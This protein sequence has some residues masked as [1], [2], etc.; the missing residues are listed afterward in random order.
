MDR[1]DDSRRFLVR[2]RGPGRLDVADSPKREF[3]D[4][5][6]RVNTGV[7][8]APNGDSI[9][10]F[11]RIPCPTIEVEAG[12]EFKFFHNLY[13]APTSSRLI[14]GHW[15]I[16]AENR[17]ENLESKPAEFDLVFSE[18]SV[19]YCL[20]HAMDDDRGTRLWARGWLRRL[21]PDLAE[22]EETPILWTDPNEVALAKAKNQKVMD[23]IAAW[24]K[25][26]RDTA[27]V[28]KAIDDVN[29]NSGLDPIKAREAVAALPV[30]TKTTKE[31]ADSQEFKQASPGAE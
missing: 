15:Q 10:V 16:V 1:P 13:P 30:P 19:D 6:G 12:G 28:R 11:R 25:K 8:K 2:C 5:F 17:L 3:D 31:K 26:N 22:E 23:A 18:R 27:E 20:K 29:R 7:G 9:R 24:W 4:Y 14:P 21:R